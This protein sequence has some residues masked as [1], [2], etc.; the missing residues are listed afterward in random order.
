VYVC[1]FVY[2]CVYL[3]VY[4]SIVRVCMCVRSRDVASALV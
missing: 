2:M 4:M 1:A 3:G